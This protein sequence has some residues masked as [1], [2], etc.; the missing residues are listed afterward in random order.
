MP[1]CRKV[2]ITNA[3]NPQFRTRNPGTCH[4]PLPATHRPTP[5]VGIQPEP[6]THTAIP[7]PHLSCSCRP[8]LVP[9]PR[10]RS[11]AS[12]LPCAIRPPCVTTTAFVVVALDACSLVLLASAARALSADGL[13]PAPPPSLPVLTAPRAV[14]TPPPPDTAAAQ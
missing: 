12:A 3:Q 6:Y 1:T 13:S 8:R 5:P 4:P 11:P 10:T 9:P 7:E 14:E 2:V